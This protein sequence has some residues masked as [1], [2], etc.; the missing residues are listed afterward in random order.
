MQ[1]DLLSKNTLSLKSRE[2]CWLI[3]SKCSLKITAGFLLRSCRVE[4]QKNSKAATKEAG[5]YSRTAS[6]R[7]SSYSNTICT[8]RSCLPKSRVLMRSSKSRCRSSTK[9]TE[10][11]PE[12]R[13]L[14]SKL[15]LLKMNKL[16]LPRT[17]L[18]TNKHSLRIENYF[19]VQLGLAMSI[20]QRKTTQI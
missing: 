1:R 2:T 20:F 3:T 16:T 19:P 4:K 14:V 7:L 15:V 5:Q 9:C 11:N 13:L 17:A 12:S 8:D 18:V 10:A 6:S